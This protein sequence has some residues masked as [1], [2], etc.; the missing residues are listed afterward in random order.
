MTF[1]ST[2][3]SHTIGVY[4]AGPRATAGTL[5]RKNELG[6]KRG[7]RKI[8]GSMQKFLR[9]A[10]AKHLE[11]GAPPRCAPNPYF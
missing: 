6:F 11:E 2:A 10:L 5:V 9:R 8:L 1:V 7:L 3:V 4:Q